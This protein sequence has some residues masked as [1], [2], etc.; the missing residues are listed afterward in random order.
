MFVAGG[1]ISAVRHGCGV[2]IA[3][4]DAFVIDKCT[5]THVTILHGL[6]QLLGFGSHIIDLN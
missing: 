3:R 5:N 1:C 6:F 2:Y 4:V